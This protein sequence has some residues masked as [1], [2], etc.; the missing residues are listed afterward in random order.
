MAFSFCVR[1]ILVISGKLCP[2]DDIFSVK[3]WTNVVSLGNYVFLG[4][5]G[6]KEV[7]SPSFARGI[8]DISV[9]RL[10]FSLYIL[11]PYKHSTKFYKQKSLA[12]SRGGVVL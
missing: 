7:P 9:R 12:V 3:S 5:I 2:Y 1:Y 4:Q 11:H 10:N 6:I 8:Q